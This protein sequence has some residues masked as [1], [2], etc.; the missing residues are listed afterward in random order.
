[1]MSEDKEACVIAGEGSGRVA[2]CVVTAMVDAGTQNFQLALAVK[3]PECALACLNNPNTLQ[4]FRFSS[5][6]SSSS[7]VCSSS[8]QQ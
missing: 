1:M 6:F 2:E 3:Q 4:T 8:I 7:S 5:L